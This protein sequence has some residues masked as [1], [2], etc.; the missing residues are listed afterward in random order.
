MLL[1][2]AIISSEYTKLFEW[3]SMEDVCAV[4][5]SNQQRLTEEKREIK[6]HYYLQN[7]CT[8]NSEHKSVQKSKLLGDHFINPSLL[9]KGVQSSSV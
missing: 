8:V 9:T 6:T 7:T 1:A 5:T 2:Y 3:P 4:K